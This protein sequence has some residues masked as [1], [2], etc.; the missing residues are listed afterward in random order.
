MNKNEIV[1]NRIDQWTLPKDVQHL[2]DNT[3]LGIMDELF[4]DVQTADELIRMVREED[5]ITYDAVRVSAVFNDGTTIDNDLIY[6]ADAD[7]VEAELET[8][9]EWFAERNPDHYLVSYYI[10]DE[11]VRAEE[12]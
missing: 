9:R 6:D 7:A 1:C 2:I 4:G 10:D 5:F 3:D 8:A 12:R 11:C